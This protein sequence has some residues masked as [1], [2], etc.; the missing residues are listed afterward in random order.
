MGS[1]P[2]RAHDAPPP[3]VFEREMGCTESEWLGW[4]DQ[5][6]GA[7]P[8]TCEGRGARVVLGEGEL[9]LAWEPLPPRE[10]ALLRLPRLRVRFA[11]SAVSAGQRTAFLRRFDL[12]M[13]RGGG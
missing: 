3:P 4:L 7:W 13:Q 12:Y 6:I 5:A 2:V 1:Y 8:W 10:V 9:H 11:F